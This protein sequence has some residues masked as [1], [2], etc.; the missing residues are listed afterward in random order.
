LHL[1]CYDPLF[2]EVA[3]QGGFDIRLIC[4]P[5]NSPDFNILDLGF[6]RAIQAIQ[7]TKVVELVPIV[8]EVKLVLN[9]CTEIFC[10]DIVPIFHS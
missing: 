2:C 4:Q 8:Q 6:F 10:Y 1:H 3:K 9:S 7:Y 5:P